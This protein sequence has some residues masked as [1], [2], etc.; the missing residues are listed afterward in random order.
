MFTFLSCEDVCMWWRVGRGGG[1]VR[2][3]RGEGVEG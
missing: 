1:G 3:W 2:E